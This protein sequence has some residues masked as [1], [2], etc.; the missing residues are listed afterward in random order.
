MTDSYE[1]KEGH[2][3]WTSDYL[4]NKGYCCRSSCLHCPYGH[5]LKTIGLE[6]KNYDQAYVDQMNQILERDGHKKTDNIALSLL[7]EIDEKKEQICLINRDKESIR[8]IFLKDYFAGFYFLEHGKADQ[9]FLADN[10][11]FQGIKEHL[12]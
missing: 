10:F 11:R 1:N 4:R 5:T 3:I 6:I 7:Q 2:R 12:L 8:L 9:V